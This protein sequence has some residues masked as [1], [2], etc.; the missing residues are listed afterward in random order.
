M[1]QR[2]FRKLTAYM[3]SCMMDPA[4]D[5][6]HVFRVL[7]GALAIAEGETV[8]YDVLI[9]A[10][11]LHDVGRPEQL[12]DPSL[13]HAE[14][15]AEKAYRFLLEQGFPEEQSERVRAC[16][17][18]H[19][20]RKGCAPESVEAKILFDADKLDAAGA[21]GIARTLIYKG[22]VSE[23]LYTLKDGKPSSDGEPSFFQEYERKLE[24]LYDK[25]Y[26]ARGAEMARER[27]NAAVSFY[28]SLCREV[29]GTYE[30]G[31][32]RLTALLGSEEEGSV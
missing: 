19:R 6:E 8:D 9:A 30:R 20:F 24:K 26:T 31:T 28:E 16:I 22:E 27:Q 3:E 21:L 25:F 11:L 2:T 23:P 12:A 32:E 18:T 17:R 29:N 4:H 7:Y 5:R 14:A 1:D 15:G 10:C 13:D